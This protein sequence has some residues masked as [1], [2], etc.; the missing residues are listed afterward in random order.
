M[1]KF[2]K[3][4]FI[5]IVPPSPSV[6]ISDVT[7]TSA[8]VTWSH[9]RPSTVESYKVRVEYLGSCLPHR[10]SIPHPMSTESN[11]LNFMITNL[12]AFSKYS[13][14]VLANNTAGQSPVSQKNNITFTTLETGSLL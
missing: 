9:D 6:S 13:V 12:A 1:S 3:F 10:N 2:S 4:T 7:E 8:V 14:I 5:I 11:T